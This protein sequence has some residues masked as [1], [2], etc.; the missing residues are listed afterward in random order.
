MSTKIDW[1]SYQRVHSDPRNLLIHVI[2]VP[3]FIASFTVLIT[4][5]VRGAYLAAVIALGFALVAMALQGR[6]HALE[7]HA[8]APFSGPGNFLK[9]WFTEQFLVFPLFVL[10]G[11]WW[12]AFRATGDES[13][14]A[15]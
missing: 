14:H 2:A 5:L 9:R 15:A 12:R 11:R 10:T 4:S 7:T 6:G 1:T 3:M 13:G 8:P